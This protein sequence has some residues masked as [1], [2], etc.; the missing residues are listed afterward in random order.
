MAHRLGLKTRTGCRKKI[1]R[2][3]WR[4]SDGRPF[5]NGP[6]Q[7]WLLAHVARR[8]GGM[9]ATTWREG[10]VNA[11]SPSSRRSSYTPVVDHQGDVAHPHLLHSPPRPTSLA[12]G[13]GRALLPVLAKP[14]RTTGL[15]ATGQPLPTTANHCSTHGRYP[16]HCRAECP[17]APE[18]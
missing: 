7:T 5:S 4:T 2:S 15:L 9:A 14:C 17:A 18:A 6:P 12:C 11:V 3:T 8:R 13:R 10:M 1:R 16:P